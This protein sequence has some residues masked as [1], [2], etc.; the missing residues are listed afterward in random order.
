MNVR[1]LIILLLAL[2]VFSC[3]QET[4]ETVCPCEELQKELPWDYPVKPGTDEWKKFE[5]VE[6][7]LAS[8]AIP[9]TVLSS[10]STEDL[11]D[12]CLNYPL[13]YDIFAFNNRNDGFNKILSDFNGIREL[14]KRKKSADALLKRY[15]NLLCW[16]DFKKDEFSPVLTV[17]ILELLL[18][19]IDWQNS[20]DTD[21]LKKILQSLV[22]GYEIERNIYYGVYSHDILF[23]TNFYSRAHIIAKMDKLSPELHPLVCCSSFANAEMVK[24]LDELSYQLIKEEA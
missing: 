16:L 6:K 21:I 8:C 10:L 20:D 2:S 19:H 23:Q 14:Y 4:P 12:I 1:N 7:M 17:S 15:E 22:S 13:L 24:L 11:T 3:N 9:D 5:S 18:S